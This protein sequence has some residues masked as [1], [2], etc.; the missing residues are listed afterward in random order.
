MAVYDAHLCF[1]EYYMYGPEGPEG[2]ETYARELLSTATSA[3]SDAGEAMARLLLGELLMLVGRTEPAE[4]E[5][6]RAMEMYASVGSLSGQS[7]SLERLAEIDIM[8]GRRPEA[9]RL[10]QEALPIAERSGIPTH[11]IVRVFGVWIAATEVASDALRVVATAEERLAGMRVCQPC[12]M[13]YLVSAGIASARAGELGRAQHFVSE[14]ERIAA[15]WQGGPWTAATWEARAEMRM[16][17]GE[18]GQAAALFREA[19]DLFASGS[20]P[21]D[22]ARCRSAAALLV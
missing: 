5:L 19:A 6:R 4:K 9:I 18:P 22:E 3:G 17:A 8:C 12:S 7:I 16:A 11:L 10:M 13:K 14:A 21:V 1:A 20:R 15:L 2:A